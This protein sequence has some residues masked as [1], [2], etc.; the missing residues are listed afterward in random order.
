MSSM[1][2]I[3]S[4]A[5]KNPPYGGGGSTTT[6]TS[7]NTTSISIAGR[8]PK[9]KTGKSPML[10]MYLSDSPRADHWTPVSIASS[11]R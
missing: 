6:K 3:G 11:G 5:P 10:E 9:E 2:G 8:V 4:W 7:S 1:S